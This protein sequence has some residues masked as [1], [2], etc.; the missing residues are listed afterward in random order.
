LDWMWDKYLSKS[1]T[2]SIAKSYCEATYI[3]ANNVQHPHKSH[4]HETHAQNMTS[5]SRTSHNYYPNL[6]MDF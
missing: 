1:L 3:H 2:S 4:T 5:M 6:I